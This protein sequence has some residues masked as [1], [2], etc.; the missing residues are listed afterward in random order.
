MA[1]KTDE[2]VIHL[3]SELKHM[4]EQYKEIREELVKCRKVLIA[5]QKELDELIT[6]TSKI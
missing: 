1:R 5:K 6:E 4:D 3:E 2:Y